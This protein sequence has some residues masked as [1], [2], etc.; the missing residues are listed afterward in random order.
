M[1]RNFVLITAVALTTFGS[2]ASA[3]ALFPFFPTYSAGYP[4]YGFGGPTYTGANFYSA[5]YAPA[6]GFAGRPAFWGGNS[7]GCC[8]TGPTVNYAAFQAPQ[9]CG[10]CNTG[11]GQCNTGCG[12]CNTGCGHC[13]AGFGSFS[14][15]AS[16]NCAD[17]NCVGANC[18]GTE[19]RS[20]PE[21][22]QDFD[23]DDRRT[24][25]TD[26]NPR[27][28]SE[29]DRRDDPNYNRRAIDS[30][31]PDPLGNDSFNR[32]TTPPD[33]LDTDADTDWN[34][35]AGSRRGSDRL[36]N[37]R[38]R[39]DFGGGGSAPG[40]NDFRD[41]ED[42]LGRK[43]PLDEIG[44]EATPNPLTDPAIDHSARKPPVSFPIG[45]EGQ[46]VDPSDF[47]PKASDLEAKATSFHEGRSFVRLAG[48]SAGQQ[49]SAAS[50]VSSS[51]VSSSRSKQRTPRW[52][53][54]PVPAGRVRL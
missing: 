36:D 27:R 34:P 41:P 20:R 11:C 23:R 7:A 29:F 54:L 52:I 28:E 24:F 37:S 3:F 49:K 8:N 10:Q 43:P 16:G 35:S 40:F 39:D 30:N 50:Q 1:K 6:F 51:Q 45:E 4:S 33:P 48:Y 2:S 53:S 32:S 5:S 15:Y 13:N 22:D 19:I 31:Q 12:Q 25:G 42:F 9:T 26:D 44:T 46:Q 21:P 47:L 18:I 17:G 38:R 14:G